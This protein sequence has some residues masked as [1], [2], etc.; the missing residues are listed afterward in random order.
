MEFVAGL[1]FILIGDL[2]HKTFGL[3]MGHEIDRCAAE[4]AAGEA[5]A[6]TSRMLASEFDEQIEFGGA[7]LEKVARA[8]VALEHVLAELAVIIIAQ[9]PFAR[10][11]ALD[12]GDNVPGAFIF[13]LS[14]SCFVRFEVSEF[15]GAQ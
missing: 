3:V 2:A 5:R 13:T 10:N 4:S 14:Q 6:E 1:V 11:D 8:F 9:C 12:F 15:N 7:V